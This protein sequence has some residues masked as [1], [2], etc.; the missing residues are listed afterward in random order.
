MDW[1]TILGIIG[2]IA[3]IITVPTAIS[4]YTNKFPFIKKIWFKIL[5]KQYNV[6]I[7]GVKEYNL[8]SYDL[9]LIKSAILYKYPQTEIT[10]PK[11]NSMTVLIKDMQAPYK[12]SFLQDYNSSEDLLKVKIVL[13]GTI[14][15]SYRNSN[16]NNKNLN[17][18][19]GIFTIIE[20]Q[21]QRMPKYKWFSLEAYTSKLENKPFKESFEII[22]CE[23]TKIEIDKKNK[24]MKINSDS[25]FNI[26]NCLN[27]N[28]IKII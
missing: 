1:M 23:D 24:Y 15:F 7:K 21:N 3:G 9:K 25:I 20:E 27:S 2:S 19:D 6:K 11:K 14:K 22:T 16:K 18:I 17:M 26:I 28:I 13:N 10:T 5:Q 12:I 8:F 4:F